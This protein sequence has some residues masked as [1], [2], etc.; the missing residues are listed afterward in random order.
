MSPY[1]CLCIAARAAA[2]MSA[3]DLASVAA[4]CSCSC[5]SL[6]DRRREFLTF[7]LCLLPCSCRRMLCGRVGGRVGGRWMGAVWVGRARAFE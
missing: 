3:R 7:S 2:S 1:I 4:S 6:R 5:F